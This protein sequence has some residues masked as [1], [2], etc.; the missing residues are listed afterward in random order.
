MKRWIL[1]ALG[2]AL[3]AAPAAA[4]PCGD[5]IAELEKRFG[6]NTPA[7]EAAKP[8]LKG[9]APETTG[10]MLHHQP[11]AGSVAGAQASADSPDA[12]RAA[13]FQVAIEQA[14]AADHS[15]DAKECEASANEAQKQL[16]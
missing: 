6:D 4:S 7:V 9:S 2:A 5:R 3:L 11:T 13:K 10:A 8:D 16:R 1:A 12:V 14:R 15:G